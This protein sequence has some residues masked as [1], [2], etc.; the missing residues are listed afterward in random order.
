MWSAVCGNLPIVVRG[1][2]REEN[3]EQNTVKLLVKL[4]GSVAADHAAPDPETF[5]ES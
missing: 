5:A 4:F 2:M 1:S 3:K